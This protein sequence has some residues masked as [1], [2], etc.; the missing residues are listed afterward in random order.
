MSLIKIGY[1]TMGDLNDFS[2]NIFINAVKVFSHCLR[3]G[4]WILRLMGVK[5]GEIRHRFGW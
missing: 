4:T 2:N 1:S 5:T 3:R